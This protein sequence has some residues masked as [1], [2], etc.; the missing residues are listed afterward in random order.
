MPLYP[1]TELMNPFFG[2]FSANPLQNTV[3]QDAML[4]NPTFFT[5]WLGNNDVLLYA[6][7]G[8]EGDSI[9]PFPLFDQ[10]MENI[11][12]TLTSGGA[13]GIIL[14]VPDVT[15]V[16]YFT[17]VP[18][19]AIV[20]TEE[21]QV[22]ALNLAYAQLNQMIIVAGST[23][24]IVFQLGANPM[25]IADASLPWQIRQIKSDEYV[26]LGLPLDSLKCAGWGTQKPV[27]SGYILDETEIADCEAAVQHYNTKL[28][29]LANAN[30]LAYLDM[31]T[32]LS[33]F[34]SGMM[35]DGVNYN[36]VF[37]QGGLFSLDGI[38]LTPQGYALVTNYIINAINAKYGAKIPLVIPNDYPGIVFP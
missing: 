16:P 38:H 28:Q 31:A 23:D 8:G 19:N 2:R 18:Y 10:A 22:E 24:T 30:S 34:K 17:T 14:G 4:V 5:L 37:V 32:V 26:T 1:V 7:G 35:F 21:S 13:K 25:I 12:A 29:E 3:L 11:V 27:P 15:S 36:T 33:D 20:L 9:T 6:V